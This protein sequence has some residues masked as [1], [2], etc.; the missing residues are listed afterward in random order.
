MYFSYILTDQPNTVILQAV[1]PSKVRE[2]PEYKT[3]TQA[4]KKRPTKYHFHTTS[5]K[6]FHGVQSNLFGG[7]DGG[8][9][10]KNVKMINYSRQS[11]PFNCR[12]YCP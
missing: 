11:R 3:Q 2:Y 7:R 1:H 6:S 9:G 8:I 4:A 10:S 12:L 5:K